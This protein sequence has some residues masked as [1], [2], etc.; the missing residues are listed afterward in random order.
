MCLLVP[1]VATAIK[2]QILNETVCISHS[3]N[4]FVKGINPYIIYPAIAKS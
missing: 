1:A 2:V 4:A 3:A